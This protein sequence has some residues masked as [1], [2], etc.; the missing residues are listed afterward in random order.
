MG[1]QVEVENSLAVALL[2]NQL[3][4]ILLDTEYYV[5]NIMCSRLVACFGP[6]L[7]HYLSHISFTYTP[8][9]LVERN[10]K[11]ADCASSKCGFCATRIS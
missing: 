6:G 5:S 11:G 3:N 8:R 4:K 9:R 7:H 2:L 1:G 10:A